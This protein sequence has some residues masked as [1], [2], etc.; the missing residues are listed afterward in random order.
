M[1][2]FDIYK[3]NGWDKKYIDL[4]ETIDLED[5]E[6]VFSLVRKLKELKILSPKEDPEEFLLC[7]DEFNMGCK[8]NWAGF[9]AFMFVL[10][11]ESCKKKWTSKL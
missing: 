2:K 3:F 7:W 9:P 11:S 8:L 1:A 6:Q 10:S 4:E 5:K